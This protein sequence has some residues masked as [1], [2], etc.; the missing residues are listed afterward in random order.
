MLPSGLYVRF[1]HAFLVYSI[2]H[3]VYFLNCGIPHGA[4]PPIGWPQP[5]FHNLSDS[6]IHVPLNATDQ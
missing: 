3:F 1:Y 2:I 6:K 5:V 4:I